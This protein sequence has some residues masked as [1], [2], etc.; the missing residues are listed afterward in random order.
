[1]I[2]KVY[3]LIPTTIFD[4]LI[5]NFFKVTRKRMYCRFFDVSFFQK[6]HHAKLT[7]CKNFGN[8][9]RGVPIFLPIL[10]HLKGGSKTALCFNSLISPKELSIPFII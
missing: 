1:M 3:F 8:L 6:L 10:S 5:N 7:P 2:P 9:V 4:L